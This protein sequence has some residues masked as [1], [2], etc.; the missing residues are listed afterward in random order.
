MHGIHKQILLLD[1]ISNNVV[2]ENVTIRIGTGKDKAEA[3]KAAI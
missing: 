1:Q 3:E 2:L